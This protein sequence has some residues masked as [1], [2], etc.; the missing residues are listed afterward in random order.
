MTKRLKIVP[1]PDKAKYD[2]ETEAVKANDGYCPCRIEKIPEN[3][4]LCQEFRHCKVANQ[5]CLCQRFMKIEVD[6]DLLD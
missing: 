2:E 4:C 1:N 6:D 3:K 5:L